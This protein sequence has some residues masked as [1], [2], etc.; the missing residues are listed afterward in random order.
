VPIVD[1]SLVALIDPEARTF[2]RIQLIEHYGYPE[3][4]LSEL[5]LDWW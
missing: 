1:N 5:D 3:D 2:S 4:D